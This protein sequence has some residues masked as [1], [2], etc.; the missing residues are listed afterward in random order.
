LSAYVGQRQAPSTDTAELADEIAAAYKDGLPGW[1]AYFLL[2]TIGETE[3]ALDV[4]EADASGGL[5]D[6]SVILFDPDIP[7]PRDTERFFALVET[8]GFVTYWQEKGPP[9]VCA[10]EPQSLLC[11]RLDRQ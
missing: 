5:L 2:G 8:L 6:T 1:F 9:T 10:D 11:R 4:V 7:G 3:A